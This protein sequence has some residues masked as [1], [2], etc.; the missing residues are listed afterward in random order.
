[1]SAR[2]NEDTAMKAVRIAPN[3][4]GRRFAVVHSRLTPGAYGVVTENFNY[5][6]HCRGGLARSWRWCADGL[7]LD[8]AEALLNKK[9]AGKRRP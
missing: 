1:M 5:A 8:D 2:N 7:S 4:A 6:G 3:K 9:L